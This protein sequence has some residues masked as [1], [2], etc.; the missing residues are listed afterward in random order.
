MMKTTEKI[1]RESLAAVIRELIEDGDDLSHTDPCLVYVRDTGEF[2]IESK[3]TP[4]DENEFV[5]ADR[6]GDTW[7]ESNASTTRSEIATTC[8]ALKTKMTDDA[9]AAA[10]AGMDDDYIAEYVIGYL[11]TEAE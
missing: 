6:I 10:M 9:V 7:L 1:D 4:R 2:S 11:D 3:L 8:E 5:V